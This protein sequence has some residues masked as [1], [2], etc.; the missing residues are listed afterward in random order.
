MIAAGIISMIFMGMYSTQY[1]E[2]DLNKTSNTLTE[3]LTE[4]FLMA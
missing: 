4:L 3:T 2:W 1:A